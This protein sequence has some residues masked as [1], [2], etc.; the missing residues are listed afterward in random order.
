MN[1]PLDGVHGPP[2][3]ANIN[4]TTRILRKQD[5]SQ[6]EQ[7]KRKG[8]QRKIPPAADA[9]AGADEH[10]DSDEPTERRE[11]GMDCLV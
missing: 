6:N 2:Q 9:R 7:K 3:I 8:E 4:A 10:A 11:G 1:A 5:E